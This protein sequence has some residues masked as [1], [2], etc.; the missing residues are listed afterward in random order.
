MTRNYPAAT[1]SRS[2]LNDIRNQFK[3]AG[4]SARNDIEPDPVAH[5]DSSRLRPQCGGY[6]EAFVIQYWASY[7]PY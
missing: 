3:K 7:G 6:N 5:S 4:N 2:F 1:T